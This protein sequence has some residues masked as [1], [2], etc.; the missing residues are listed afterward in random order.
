MTATQNGEQLAPHACNA[1]K[2]QKRKCTKELPKCSLC[3]RMSR[4]CDYSN[5][6]FSLSGENAQALQ[7]RISELE[8]LL[9]QREQQLEQVSLHMCQPKEVTNPVARHLNSNP[10]EQFPALFFLDYDIFKE[11]RMTIPKPSPPVPEEIYQML[12]SVD[13]LRRIASLFFVDVHPWFP[14]LCQKRFE[15]LLGDPAFVPS[16]DMALLFA[17][18]NLLTDGGSNSLQSIKSTL[19]W[20]VKN[21]SVVLEANAVMTPQLIQ[22][23]MLIT[24]YELA[25][26]IYPAAYLSVGNCVVLCKAYGLDNRKEAP[27]ML[28]RYG[29]WAEIEELRRLWWAGLVLDR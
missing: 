24:V 6:T 21:Y 1:C 9:L 26:A 4:E 18:M 10:F 15:L 3:A 22:A 13:G 19:Y 29:A 28:R 23:K 11:A 7:N 8:N 14:L 17:A 12:G 16:P 5:D 27:Q 25:H 20:G 2:R